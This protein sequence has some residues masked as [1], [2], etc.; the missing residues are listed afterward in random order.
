MKFINIYDKSLTIAMLTI[1]DSQNHKVAQI[2][3][4]Y[5]LKE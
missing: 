2:K 5:G 3:W 1:I 4:F